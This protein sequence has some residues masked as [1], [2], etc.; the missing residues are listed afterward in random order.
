MVIWARHMYDAGSLPLAC[1]FGEQFKTVPFDQTFYVSM[2]VESATESGMVANIITHDE[3][4]R[5]YN[6]ISGAE[7][8]I[9]KQ[10][11]PLFLQNQ[12]G[13]KS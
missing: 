5:L 10:L 12:P 1:K 7:V 6:R 13:T 2:K 11:N 9:S 8:T 4:G 3:Q